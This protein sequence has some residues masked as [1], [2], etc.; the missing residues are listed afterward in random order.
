MGMAAKIRAI[1]TG[2]CISNHFY[3]PEGVRSFRQ[4]SG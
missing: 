1:C 4:D 2:V 3:Y